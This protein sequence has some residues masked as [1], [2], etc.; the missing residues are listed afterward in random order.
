MAPLES[1]EKEY[2][3]ID[4][5][6]Q[7]F[8]ASHGI[9][10]VEDFLLHDLDALLSFTDNHSTSQ[11]L[12]Q[13]IDQL[14]SIIDA[15]HPP[16]LNGLQ[17]LEDAQRNKHVLSTGCEGID[18]LL[19]GGLRE[20]QLTELVGSSSSGK[21]QAC[22][23]SASTVVAKHK[24]SVIYLDTGNSFSPQRIAHFVGQSSGHIFG[25]QADHMLKKVLD[26]IIC[27]SVFDV[28]QMF[29]VL[30]QLKINLRS[31]IVKSNQHVR[32][33]IV[34]SISSL[35]TPILG[36]S[37]PQGHA[38]MISAGF[39]L[40]KLAHEHNIAVLVTNHV[41]GGDDGISKP[42]MGESW[43]SVPHVRILLSRDCGSNVC[44]ISILKHPS[45]VCHLIRKFLYD[46][47]Y[48]S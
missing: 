8:C 12:K 44:N 43:K 19:R 21:T 20:G 31:E 22:L 26:R 7:S 18:A 27:Y 33:L 5:N 40:K 9:F 48:V 1:L 45:M 28:Y 38:L 11:T 30:H 14:I 39:L 24:S 35:I 34:D 17:L 42:A 4:S 41:V 10:S 32:L 46:V 2:P 16:L 6:F 25:N 3:L 47:V 15:L 29:D 37:G 13:G 36:G 23:L